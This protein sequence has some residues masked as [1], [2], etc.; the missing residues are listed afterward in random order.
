MTKLINKKMLC[1]ASEKTFF[2][3]SAAWWWC[4]K[5]F[6]GWLGIMKSF[7]LI[8][9]TIS[10]WHT[11]K[12]LRND[13]MATNAE[14]IK[15]INCILI[16]QL[17]PTKKKK[18][19]FFV[20]GVEDRRVRQPWG[21]MLKNKKNLTFTQKRF[22]MATLNTWKQ[23]KNAHTKKTYHTHCVQETH[24]RKT[25]KKINDAGVSNWLV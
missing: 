16:F 20:S 3:F 13:A 24:N 21:K 17:Q 18:Y 11:A 25:L 9:L 12:T 4:M 1:F 2:L 23:H 14:P 5:L 7:L 19:F 6:K 22:L 8:V 10:H 15:L